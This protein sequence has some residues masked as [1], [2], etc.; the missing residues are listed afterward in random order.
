MYPYIF[1]IGAINTTAAD[2][3]VKSY[4]PPPPPKLRDFMNPEIGERMYDTD[5]M[6]QQEQLT[7]ILNISNR[8]PLSTHISLL[9]FLWYIGKQCRTRSGATECG[10]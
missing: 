10:V 3:E 5:N 8:C 2:I 4:K 9:S 6:F 1:V 7:G